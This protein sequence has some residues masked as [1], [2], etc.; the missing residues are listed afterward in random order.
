M[1]LLD[2][3]NSIHESLL[4]NKYKKL[5]D[6][7]LKLEDPTPKQ[8]ADFEVA[9]KETEDKQRDRTNME[10]AIVRHWNTYQSIV[11][12]PRYP[13]DE[14]DFIRSENR[15]KKG[16]AGIKI[17]GDTVVEGKVNTGV[18]AGV[19]SEALDT[20]WKKYLLTVGDTAAAATAT[21]AVTD[22]APKK[23]KKPAKRVAAAAA[24]PV[25]TVAQSLDTISDAF[26]KLIKDEHFIVVIGVNPEVSKAVDDL[27]I[28]LDKGEPV[29]E[30]NRLW[31]LLRENIPNSTACQGEGCNA[32]N[33][34]LQHGLCIS[35][36]VQD[37]EERQELIIDRYHV[38]EEEHNIDIAKRK[39]P[40]I[41]KDA[42]KQR[43]N[44]M[45]QLREEHDELYTAFT[46][47]GG[48]KGYD[49]YKAIYDKLD[50]LLPTQSSKKKRVRHFE[51]KDEEIGS[52]EQEMS[53]E[54]END[55][56]ISHSG[57]DSEYE[58]DSSSSHSGAI[59]KKNK[60]RSSGGSFTGPILDFFS[61]L[62]PEIGRLSEVYKTE[63]TNFAKE[64]E[65]TRK[66]RMPRFKVVP[67]VIAT[68][69]DAPIA[70]DPPNIFMTEEAAIKRGE[71]ATVDMAGTIS[72]RVMKI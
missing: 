72:F 28:I 64:F 17:E 53:D 10:A 70:F 5:R 71:E 50:A 66:N 68:G 46:Q 2:R 13:K 19:T 38:F 63:P 8:I 37:V 25:A 45:A 9:F 4:T 67:V 22:A 1:S 39:V 20:K 47:S 32:S 7:F 24:G 41:E 35:C 18:L 58:S 49:A 14:A 33:T 40:Q 34:K 65:E 6:A 16:F 43:H 61:P 57:G 51:A 42:L 21:A 30:A 26:N 15:L 52:E 44:T 60:K 31:S 54:S 3:I 69:K 59:I 11:N 36:L 56:P 27:K 29:D 12:D 62:H 23:K 48:N 55:E